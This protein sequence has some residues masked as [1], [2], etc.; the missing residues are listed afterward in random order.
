MTAPG[1]GRSKVGDVILIGRSFSRGLCHWMK[2]N[3][4]FTHRFRKQDS[5]LGVSRN[6]S[7]VI[8]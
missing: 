8:A 2:H 4:V 3:D 1:G 7:S 5:N 6:V